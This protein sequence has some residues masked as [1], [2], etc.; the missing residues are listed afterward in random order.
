MEITGTNDPARKSWALLAFYRYFAGELADIYMQRA[1]AV[2]DAFFK[3]VTGIH[4]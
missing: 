1:D 4:V 2:K 3:L